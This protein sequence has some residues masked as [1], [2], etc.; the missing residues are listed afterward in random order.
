MELGKTLGDSFEYAKEGLVGK[1]ARWILLIISCIVFP[2]IM[3]YV[4]RIYRGVVPSPEL[5]EWGGMFIDGIKLFIVAIIYAIPIIIVEFAV[6]GSAGVA[7]LTTMSNPMA[8]PNAVMAL[9]GSVL[10]GVIILILVAIIIELIAIIGMVRFARTNSFGQAFNFGAIFD[11]IGRIGIASY[12]LALIVLAIIVGIIEVICLVIPY[13][14]LLI[15]FILLP[16]IV[17]FSA[18]YVTLVYESAGVEVST[19]S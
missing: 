3:G 12:I 2:L 5:D 1:W 15:L 10:F 13:I 18:R 4:M 8:D 16:F 17:L 9:V 11:T 19:P 14:G 7:F 6:I